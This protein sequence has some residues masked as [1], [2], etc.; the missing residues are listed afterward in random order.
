M[1]WARHMMVDE[2]RWMTDAEFVDVLAVAQLLPGPNIVNVS[3]GVGARFHGVPG[4]VMAFAGLMV[5]PVALV[6]VLGS[7]YAR[8]DDL[9]SFRGAFGGIAAVAAGMVITTALRIAP[10][11][12][13]RPAAIVIAALAFVGVGILRWPLAWVVFGLAPLSL[14][15]ALWERR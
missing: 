10:L 3:I 9:A 6:I 14:A 13:G 4:A 15:V 11:V 5:V 2:K 1:P 8:L 12:R 7:L